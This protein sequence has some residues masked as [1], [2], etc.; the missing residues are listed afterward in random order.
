MYSVELSQVI[1]AH[2]HIIF[3]ADR[4]YIVPSETDTFQ[5]FIGIIGVFKYTHTHTLIHTYP[6]M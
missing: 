1:I 3:C 6:H 5:R 4:E 2:L